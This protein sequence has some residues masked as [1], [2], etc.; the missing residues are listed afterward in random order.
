[1]YIYPIKPDEIYHYGM[2]ERSGRYAWGSGDRPYQRLEGKVSRMENRLKKKFSK[3]DLRTSKLQENINKKMDKAN[4]Q[5]NSI[6][7]S[8][9]TKAERSFNEAYSLEEK[10]QRAEYKMSK[11]YEKYFDKF[12]KFNVQMDS[13]LQTKGLEYYNRVVANT[14]TQY[15]AALIK[16]VS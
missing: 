4:A 15:K 16:R 1:M 5:R 14:E 8:R 12:S 11:T 6:F 9:R 7:K 13:D 3:T 10:K 2:P